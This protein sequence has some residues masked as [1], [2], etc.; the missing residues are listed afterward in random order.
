ML[1]FFTFLKLTL[2]Y[3]APSGHFMMIIGQHNTY[4]CVRSN[5]NESYFDKT[6]GR[7]NGFVIKTN[8]KCSFFLDINISNYG[9]SFR[10]DKK[11]IKVSVQ[12]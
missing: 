2:A 1:N 3:R 5:I 8:C 11:S 7:L 6:F 9:I 4:F 10:T 12:A